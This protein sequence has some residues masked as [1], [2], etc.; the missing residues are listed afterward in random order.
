[1]GTSDK[2]ILRAGARRALA[3]MKPTAEGSGS[4]M[5]DRD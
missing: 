4:I 3:R 2:K 5:F 1:M